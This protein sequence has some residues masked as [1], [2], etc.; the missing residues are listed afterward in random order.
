MGL[1]SSGRCNTRGITV[2]M[3]PPGRLRT[4][5]VTILWSLTDSALTDSA[6][7]DSALTDS[8]LTAFSLFGAFMTILAD[9]TY[10]SIQTPN[11]ARRLLILDSS[12]LLVGRHPIYDPACG[13]LLD[14]RAAI[15][16]NNGY[17][18]FK[19][20]QY[21]VE[22]SGNSATISYVDDYM[23]MTGAHEPFDPASW[24]W[25]PLI[26]SSFWSCPGHLARPSR[27]GRG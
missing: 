24:T 20:G 27:P 7:T 12:C 6:L 15:S 3:I 18:P 4:A 2:S 21:S 11:G 26:R 22:W 8:A 13:P 5:A 16:T 19:D 14:F 9:T 17:D 1:A 23:E 25:R 10:R